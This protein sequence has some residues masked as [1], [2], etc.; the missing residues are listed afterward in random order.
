MLLSL[1]N[2]LLL[3]ITDHLADTSDIHSLAMT[4]KHLSKLVQA[5]L[6]KESQRMQDDAKAVGQSLIHFAAFENN[7]R[8]AK[9]ALTL[10]ADCIDEP[11][12]DYGTALHITVENAFPEMLQFLLDRGAD[13]NYKQKSAFIDITP[14]NSILD[15]IQWIGLNN[16]PYPTIEIQI[17]QQL[18]NSGADPRIADTFYGNAFHRAVVGRI[19][20][21]V[22]SILDS[23]LIDINSQDSKGLTVLHKAVQYWG[24]PTVEVLEVLL[25]RG[26]NLD[27]RDHKGRTALFHAWL[28]EHGVRF[29]ALLMKYGC[30]MNV[31]DVNGRTV[32]HWI[33]KCKEPA[34]AIRSMEQ[35]LSC[36]TPCLI[37][38][39]DCSGK[40]A[41][42]Y[43]AL[44]CNWELVDM[45]MGYEA[46]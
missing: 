32:F 46:K 21:L 10:N 20:E 11:L 33:A 13:P 29:T 23:G 37:Y 9:L 40:T 43:A 19:P 28:L 14:L 31:R 16:K 17:A 38:S 24:G 8:T 12:I 15:M 1:P 39:E 30:D 6:D 36:Q 22:T 35:V 34:R 7:I 25:Q 45:L 3:E 2:E 5:R 18:L 26:I 41:S 27:L 4:C 42:D 44:N